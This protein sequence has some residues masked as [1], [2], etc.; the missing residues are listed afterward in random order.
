M[1]EGTAKKRAIRENGQ[2]PTGNA[3]MGVRNNV[4]NSQE[5]APVWSPCAI[6]GE[7]ELFRGGCR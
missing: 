4:N 1:R 7:G 6:N 3:G 5:H 2:M